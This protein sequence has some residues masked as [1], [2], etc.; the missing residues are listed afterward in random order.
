MKQISIILN[1]RETADAINIFIDNIQKLD[2]EIQT[3]SII[4]TA[5]A[6]LINEIKQN[7]NIHLD[8]NFHTDLIDITWEHCAIRQYL[9]GP[10][11]ESFSPDERAQIL[12]TRISDRD[13]PWTGTK[14]GNPTIDKIFLLSYDEVIK[15][16][17]D[18]G[19]LKN[20]QGWIWTEVEGFSN[21]IAVKSTADLIDGQFINDQ[22]CT[23]RRSYKTDGSLGWWWL[24]S[25][26]GAGQHTSGS[27]GIT[28]EI[29][30]CGDDVFMHP[31]RDINGD[32]R[33]RPVMWVKF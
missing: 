21:D 28:G 24:R 1:N 29:F 11:Y 31:H 15:Y 4:R 5:L 3:L 9:N 14:C 32:D 8:F 18:S 12:E 26:G 19:D 16:F 17:G 6:E 25:P 30:L 2:A 27:I 23:A 13:N 10:F 7:D 22:Y 20:R 33:V